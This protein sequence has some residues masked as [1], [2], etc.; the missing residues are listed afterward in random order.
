MQTSLPSLCQLSTVQAKINKR[1]QG[2]IIICIPSS[3][4]PVI[5]NSKIVI[6]CSL[7]YWTYRWH[8]G[9]SLTMLHIP[10]FLYTAH[11]PE[12][13]KSDQTFSVTTKFLDIL[14]YQSFIKSYIANHLEFK[15]LCWI[16]YKINISK[17]TGTYIIFH[18]YS[19]NIKI[20][21]L[22]KF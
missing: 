15:N 8:N 5:F 12:W 3:L 10:S 21:Y 2:K 11:I 20:T 13:E 7:L 16:L 22:W 14:V 17:A 4:I 18:I 6:S 9:K 1:C 19:S